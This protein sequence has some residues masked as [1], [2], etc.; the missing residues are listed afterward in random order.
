MVRSTKKWIWLGVLLVVV[1]LAMFTAVLWGQNFDFS[2][3]STERYV[4][5]TYEI[6][7]PWRGISIESDTADITF[8]LSQDGKCKVSCYEEENARH[9]VTVK[10]E[11]LTISVV[12]TREWYDHI[13]IHWDSPKITVYLPQGEYGQ[14]E[15]KERTGDIRVPNG[16]TFSYVD[17]STA[18]GGVEVAASADS[19]M[20]INTTTGDISVTNTSVGSLYLGVSTGRISVENVVC[21]GN[22]DVRVS[23]GKTVFTDVTCKELASKGDTGDI[24]LERVIMEGLCSI[25]RGTGN[26]HFAESDALSIMVET[27]TGNVTGSLLNSKVF[28]VETDTGRVN[29]PKSD[30]D[31][32]C[33]VKTDTGDITITVTELQ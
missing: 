22:V 26:V 27:E 24:R 33:Y 28:L 2:S 23:T 12:D 4:T 21:Q 17:I 29:V 18:T 16:L 13:G 10:D 31:G 20:K 6:N 30:G 14:L 8:L 11:V 3:L 32:R 5:N 7:D 15:V 9:A 1:G 19:V 25:Q